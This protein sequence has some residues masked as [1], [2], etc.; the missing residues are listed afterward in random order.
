[1]SHYAQ[2]KNGRV[3]KVIVAEADFVASLPD[4]ADWIQTSY[5]TYKN[6]H[7]LGGTP[8]RGNYAAPGFVYDS[9]NDVFY[10]AQPYASWTLDTQTWSWQAPV[11]YPT[12]DE[13][14]YWDENKKNW[15]VTPRLGQ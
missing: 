4:A 11:P 2:V 12:D 15:V 9:A 7:R 14:Y 10:P 3:Q 1:M 5:N 6:Q 13:F 8:L